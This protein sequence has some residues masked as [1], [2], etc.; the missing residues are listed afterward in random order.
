MTKY[1]QTFL[2]IFCVF[3]TIAS[4]GVV[5]IGGIYG[6]I[7]GGID[8]GIYG[9]IDDKLGLENGQKMINE[10]NFAL[11]TCNARENRIQDL[12]GGKV[13]GG[14]KCENGFCADGIIV[15]AALYIKG[16]NPGPIKDGECVRGMCKGNPRSGLYEDNMWVI[17]QM[18]PQVFINH[19][20]YWPSDMTYPDPLGCYVQHNLATPTPVPAPVAAPV[21]VPVAVPVV[22]LPAPPAPVV[23]S[24][25]QPPVE[26]IRTVIKEVTLPPVAVSKPP[27]SSS[28][29]PILWIVIGLGGL[30]LIGVV[31]WVGLDGIKNIFSKNRREVA[32]L[33]K[34][35]EKETQKTQQKQ[36]VADLQD[37]IAKEMEKREK[38]IDKKWTAKERKEVAKTVEKNLETQYAKLHARGINTADIA[39]DQAKVAEDMTALV[40]AQRTAKDAKKREL[41]QRGIVDAM[42][43]KSQ[44]E[45]W[46]E[47]DKK[48]ELV[49]LEDERQKLMELQVRRTELEQM[50]IQRQSTV[51][52]AFEFSME[53]SKK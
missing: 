51:D 4:Q 11:E 16:L 27:K 12:Y 41:A 19:P 44:S 36:T 49:R 52:Q 22:V 38:D 3:A 6:G 32:E 43:A 31:G 21:P 30:I 47:E 35:L 42:V 18:Y 28:P 46:E 45:N 26:I 8:G 40:V 5:G 2:V 20:E 15:N 25:D 50:A 1:W 53:F 10:G 24:N 17:G 9:G 14:N 23:P 33:E 7:D 48:K 13:G 29:L 37:R 34:E 39:A